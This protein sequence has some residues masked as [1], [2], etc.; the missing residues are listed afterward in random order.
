[1][2]AVSAVLGSE[3]TFESG[4][5][6]GFVGGYGDFYIEEMEGVVEGSV[7]VSL[8]EIVFVMGRSG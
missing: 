6:V 4:L 7:S 1:M 5:C 3:G 8:A 2:S